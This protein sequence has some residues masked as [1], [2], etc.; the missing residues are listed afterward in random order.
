M[1][2]IKEQVAAQ[3]GS[4]AEAYRTS[5][6]HA[7]GA[8][9]ARMVE[10][11]A[12]RGDEVVLDAGCGAGH[13]ALAFARV[14]QSVVAVDLSAE[15]LGVAQALAH[16]RGLE[17]VTF[18][19]GDVEALPAQDGEFDLVVSR[20]SAHHWPHPQQALREIRRVLK[21][22]GRFILSD[23]V[24]Y[25]EFTADSYLQTVE[26]LRDPSHV[27]D[28]SAA[29]W[30]AMMTEAGFNAA[31]VH[32]FDCWLEFDAWVKRI[33]TPPQNVAA[34]RSLMTNAPV[35]VKQALR[36]ETGGDFTLQGAI[37]VGRVL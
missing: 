10:I 35:E 34:L 27:R 21:P 7:S 29:Q 25:E 32:I 9:L 1:N 30:V 17:N 33:N 11:G 15:M 22:G 36:I 28:H 2:G 37:V 14:A 24:S 18:R 8:D 26:V 16:E 23:I 13:T 4:A 5:T 6:V 31:L 20:Y 12:L 19:Q 3:F